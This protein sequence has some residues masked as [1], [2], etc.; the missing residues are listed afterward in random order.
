MSGNPI[1]RLAALLGLVAV[2]L[3]AYGVVTG[4]L[5][6]VEAAKRAG[7]TLFAVI[8]V[9]AIGRV[10]LSALA[11]SMERASIAEQPRR[12]ATDQV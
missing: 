11:G 2:G 6:L 4:S 5:E 7:L 12:R 9:R 1:N 3:I 10:G 8:V